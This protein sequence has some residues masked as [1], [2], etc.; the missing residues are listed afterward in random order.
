MNAVSVQMWQ[1]WVRPVAMQCSASTYTVFGHFDVSSGLLPGQAILNAFFIYNESLA[2]LAKEQY[3]DATMLDEAKS[4]KNS[5]TTMYQRAMNGSSVIHF[6]PIKLR[7]Y[8]NFAP[9]SVKRPELNQ[10]HL[11]GERE[12]PTQAGVL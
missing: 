5:F 7:L 3:Y 2:S 6:P 4:A 1:R 9:V 11:L 8:K 12:P 10:T